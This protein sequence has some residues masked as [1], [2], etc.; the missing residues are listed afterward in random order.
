MAEAGRR[1]VLGLLNPGAMGGAVG[2]ALRAGGTRVLW[3]SEGRSPATRK[4]A[5]SA[6]LED[7]GT[8]SALVAASDIVLSVCP[9]ESAA[10]VA[11]DVVAKKFAGIYLDANAIAPATARD[12]ALIVEQGGATFVDGG[13][14]GPPPKTRGTTRLYLSG[15]QADR[16]AALFGPGPLEA[17]VVDGKV[18]AASALKMAYAAWTKGS[19]ALLMAVRAFAIAEGVDEG[20][21]DE[22]RRSQPDLPRRS[23]Q[24]VQGTSPKAWRFVGEMDEIAA[25]FAEAS[26]PSAFHQAAAEVYRRL[27]EYKDTTEP[28]SVA[29]AADRLRG[30][31]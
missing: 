7:A 6:G 19:Q 23:E 11:R 1:S 2:A 9:P 16:I 22:W 26:L 28:P 30:V 3:A 4:R 13:I 14:V 29:E 10:D 5:E 18:G 12:I 21:L 20:L 31:H 15:V 25:A 24:A 8:V 17:I 27:A